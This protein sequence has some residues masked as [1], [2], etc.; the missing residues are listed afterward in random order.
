MTRPTINTDG[1]SQSEIDQHLPIFEKMLDE[2]EA[3][4]PVSVDIPGD[5]AGFL[6]IQDA[7]NVHQL[8]TLA[9][10]GHIDLPTYAAAQ[11]YHGANPSPEQL[12]A[13]LELQPLG[14]ELHGC[15]DAAIERLAG[16]AATSLTVYALTVPEQIAWCTSPDRIMSENLIVEEDDDGEED[17]GE[18]E[19]PASFAFDDA[20][21]GTALTDASL[22][23]LSTL[24]SLQ[25]LAVIGT[26]FTDAALAEVT[27]SDQ[28][29][30]LTLHSFTA[31][32]SDPS[33]L[34][35]PECKHLSL[36]G[37][38]MSAASLAA[39]PV[40][41]GLRAVT[42]RDIDPSDI[43]GAK[44]ARALPGLRELSIYDD[45]GVAVPSRDMLRLHAALPGVEINEST[46]SPKAIERMAAKQGITL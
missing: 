1:W 35:G 42:L 36:F 31:T 8:Y 12:D 7:D 34:V 4:G 20:S 43:D 46:L 26:D 19:A 9:A 10:Q 30:S 13:I 41:P 2:L 3:R 37:A 21:I 33:N 32:F 5:S 44:L 18:E 24:T 45:Q 17:A 38:T 22:K 16:S 6:L 15:S 11:L 39:W 28:L 25:D 40:M 29:I 27:V 23:P 14:L